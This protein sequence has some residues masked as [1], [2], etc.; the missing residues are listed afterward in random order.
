MRVALVTAATAKPCRGNFTTI[1]RWLHHRYSWE[2]VRVSPEPDHV[3]D[4]VPDVVHG[5]HA[6]HG[7]IAAQAIAA[8]HKRPLVISIG[9][10]DLWR[11]MENRDRA[12]EVRGVLATTACISG[13]FESFGRILEG[14]LDEMPPYVVVPRAIALPALEPPVREE[15]VLRVLL[16]AGLRD[17]KDPMLGIEMADELVRRGLPIRL[18][19]LG[20]TIEEDYA[21]RLRERARDLDFVR[22]EVR[23]PELVAQV[24]REHDVCWNTSVHEGGANALLE[25]LAYGHAVFARDVLGNRDFFEGDDAPATLFEPADLEHA[26]RFHRAVLEESDLA[27]LARV[28]QARAWLEKHHSAELEARALERAW[29]AAL[30]S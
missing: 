28:Q 29:A 26:E 5:Y 16:P 18:T 30:R 10:T 1:Q 11:L 4:P 3:L 22:F 14:L 17:V 13:A 24:Y 19:I 27:R 12:D 21:E 2:F 23:P 6:L 8:R 7:G 9:G 25:G 20:P 15:G